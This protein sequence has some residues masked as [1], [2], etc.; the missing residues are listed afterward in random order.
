MRYRSTRLG[1]AGN[2]IS[3]GRSAED[4]RTRVAYVPR[5]YWDG[6]VVHQGLRWIMDWRWQLQA[7][8]N[9]SKPTLVVVLP[10]APRIDVYL[11]QHFPALGF[12][13]CNFRAQDCERT[14]PNQTGW[15]ALFLH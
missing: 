11:F 7:N 1:A 12:T 9:N 8:Y 10:L 15:N 4:A 3:A 13:K 14:S 5:Q 6:S 2:P